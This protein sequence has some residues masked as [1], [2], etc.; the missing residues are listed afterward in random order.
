MTKNGK[1]L[2]VYDLD[3]NGFV[4]H[5]GKSKMISQFLLKS[6]LV[7]ITGVTT[8]DTAPDFHYEKKKMACEC[9]GR[10]KGSTM[11]LI[12]DSFYI[13]PCYRCER[14][15]SWPRVKEEIRNWVRE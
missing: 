13:G 5:E 15:N 3:D 2:S 6:G 10:V 7:D 11:L 1:K 9:K 4:M 8:A 12:S 14:W